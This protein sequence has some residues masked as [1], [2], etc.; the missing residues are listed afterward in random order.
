[1]IGCFFCSINITIIYHKS[2]GYFLEFQRNNR[3]ISLYPPKKKETQ[4]LIIGNRVWM[5]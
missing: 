1:M 5:T 4:N 2:N 3:F